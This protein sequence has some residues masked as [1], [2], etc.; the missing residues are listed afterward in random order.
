MIDYLN[1]FGDGWEHRLIVSDVRAG[2]PDLSHP[3]CIAGAR[4]AP[5]I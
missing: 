2:D 4:N 5:P 3:R 1:D